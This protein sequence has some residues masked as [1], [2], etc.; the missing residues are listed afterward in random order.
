M[1]R[2]PTR[3][4]RPLPAPS[5]RQTREDVE[6]L[7]AIHGV[8]RA[9]PAGIIGVL[10]VLSCT[11]GPTAPEVID[12]RP[13]VIGAAASN[14]DAD[15]MFV[16][17]PPVVPPHPLRQL[18]LS[19]ALSIA[20]LVPRFFYRSAGGFWEQEH[21]GPIDPA[22]LRRCGRVLYAYSPFQPLP[23]EWDQI[24]HRLFGPWWLFGFCGQRGDMQLSV[25]VS[26]FATDLTIV[27][28]AIGFPNNSGVELQFQGAPSTWQ[29]AVTL[30]PE[31]ATRLAASCTGRRVAEVP[32]L[33]AGSF[34]P[35]HVAKWRLRLDTPVRL[36]RRDTGDLVEVNEVFAGLY[37]GYGPDGQHQPPPSIGIALPEQPASIPFTR[38]TNPPAPND[39][40]Q[41]PAEQTFEDVQVPVRPD[42]PI[43]LAE[44]RCNR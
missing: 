18:A 21:G 35:V 5:E 39:P 31:G 32:V 2:P 15:G 33:L 17:P 38:R 34:Q 40:P 4:V 25:G 28:D 12:V 19:E 10:F 29:A 9:R 26:A 6:V 1:L 44:V 24:E 36:Q 7:D 3:P 37:N 11:D 30:S 16:L 14:L 23:A 27:G 42:H 8:R 22:Q 43:A 13:F 20:V 41:D